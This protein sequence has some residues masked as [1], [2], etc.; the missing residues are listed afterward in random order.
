MGTGAQATGWPPWTHLV[1]AA[2]PGQC[3]H[4]AR[5]TQGRGATPICPGWH[6]DPPICL[7]GDAEETP[8]TPR[9]GGAARALLLRPSAPALHTLH[10]FCPVPGGGDP[11]TLGSVTSPPRQCAEQGPH[12]FRGAQGTGNGRSLCLRGSPRGG[13][14]KHEGPDWLANA[15]ATEAAAVPARRRQEPLRLWV[16]PVLWTQDGTRRAGSHSCCPGGPR[17]HGH[18]PA[19]RPLIQ[20]QLPPTAWQGQA[21]TQDS[22]WEADAEVRAG[23][24]SVLLGSAHICSRTRVHAGHWVPAAG[25]G[26]QQP[27]L[28]PSPSGTC[29]AWLTA[30]ASARLPDRDSMGLIHRLPSPGTC[31][32]SSP[33]ICRL[34]CWALRAAPGAGGSCPRGGGTANLFPA[35][36][37]LGTRPLILTPSGLHCEHTPRA[38]SRAVSLWAQAGHTGHLGQGQA[39]G[40]S[41]RCR[42]REG[43]R[44]YL[45]WVQ[46]CLAATAV[47][48]QRLPMC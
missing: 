40:R 7:L 39:E 10:L 34:R 8:R 44:G 24:V 32:N 48:P 41:Q 21:S 22:S 29:P 6:T 42:G 37:A 3:R 12:G 27:E 30:C 38:P 43:L 17:A 28:Q 45:A 36:W 5:G 23:G 13:L 11:K 2:G 4:G 33:I 47:W 9:G 16:S 18:S 35:G 19:P 26:T 20:G 15:Q 25:P 1:G 46:C 14:H 31:R